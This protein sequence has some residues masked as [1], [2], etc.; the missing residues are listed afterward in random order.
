LSNN[1]VGSSTNATAIVG[2]R[3]IGDLYR[4][5]SK[6]ALDD[7]ENNINQSNTNP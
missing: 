5:K 7:K 3:K 1:T 4:D 2:K 6:P